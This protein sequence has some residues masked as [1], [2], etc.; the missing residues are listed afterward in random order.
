VWWAHLAE[1]RL[2]QRQTQAYWLSRERMPLA[3]TASKLRD[4]YFADEVPPT[5]REHRSS[6]SRFFGC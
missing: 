1:A 3:E 4:Q 6:P 2:P 5:T